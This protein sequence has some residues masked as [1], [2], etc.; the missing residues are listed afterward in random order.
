MINLVIIY[1]IVLYISIP[2]L[3]SKAGYNFFL[4][5]IPIYNVYLLLKVL[6]IPLSIIITLVLGLIF[7]NNNVYVLTLIFIFL[8]F[9]LADAYS[10]GKILSIIGLILPIIVFP[11]LAYAP[12]ALYTYGTQVK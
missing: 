8:P 12:S 9:I 3:L 10:K 6:E 5:L 1:L 11:Y 2:G 4:G 7:L